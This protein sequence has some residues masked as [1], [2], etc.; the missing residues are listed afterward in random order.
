MEREEE[1]ERQ[2]MRGTKRRIFILQTRVIASNIVKLN[3]L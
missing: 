3:T 2:A 1:E